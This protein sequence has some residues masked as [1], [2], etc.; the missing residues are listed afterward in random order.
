VE[1]S[2]QKEVTS[3]WFDNVDEGMSDEITL[4]RASY[5]FKVT[6]LRNF[7]PL[8]PILPPP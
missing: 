3:R 1:N 7:S 6:K 2:T 5:P 8:T 4:E